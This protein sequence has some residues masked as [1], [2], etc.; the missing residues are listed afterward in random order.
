MSEF[1]SLKDHVYN[2]IADQI[3]GGTLK[4]GEKINENQICEKL[5]ISRTPVREAMIQLSTEGF[6]ENI[7]RKGFVLRPLNVNEAKEIYEIIGTLDGLSAY[8][9]CD[10][11][12][13]A[14]L[15]EMD[16][17]VQSMG[18]AI[19]TENYAMY[20]KQQEEFHNI[21]LDVC[22]NNQLITY[23]LQ[24]KKKFFNKQ[25]VSNTVKA[26]KELLYS[27]NE[28]HKQILSLF[29]AKEKNQLERY[30]RFVHWNSDNALGEKL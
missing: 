5:N 13:E 18:L 26:E 24:L 27:I 14:L 4:P 20:Y 7:P 8:L 6:L 15:K 25:Y 22:G 21:Y 30:I 23:L 2:Y 3:R 10:R 29:Q 9:A 11:M 19:D 1:L 28:E 16:F 17:Y 12:S